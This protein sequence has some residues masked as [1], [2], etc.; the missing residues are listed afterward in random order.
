M[1]T[2]VIVIGGSDQGRQVID[3][4][5]EAGGAEV[6]GVLDRRGAGADH[7]VGYPVLGSDDELAAIAASIRATAFIA[8]I[9]QNFDRHRV[10]TREIASCP[11]LEPYRVIHPSA[12][13]ARDAVIGPGSIVM[14]GVVVSNG[15]RIGTGALLGT[16]A[17]LDHDCAVGD[18]T[19][20]APGVTTGGH[21]DVGDRS[22]LG[23]G[24]NVIHGVTIGA[25][26]VV[27]AGALVVDDLADRVVAYGVPARVARSREIDEAYLG[28]HAERR[29]DPA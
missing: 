6:V 4:I 29:T 2:R 21:V 19:S 1:T 20:L 10:L 24:A 27:G 13:V 15:C 5:E 11:D 26:T 25:D 12:I 17:S 8:A 18:F 9:G 23:L 3:I 22:A 14:A 28:R 16:R 7:V